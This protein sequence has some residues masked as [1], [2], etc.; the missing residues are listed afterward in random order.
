MP[1]TYLTTPIYYVNDRPHIGHAYTSLATDVL[2][3]WKRLDGHDVHFLT[4]TD[5]HGQKVEKA[6]QD[7]GMDPQ[8][9]TDRVSQHFRD[10]ADRMGFSHD[11]FIR[12]TEPRHKA[13]CQALWEE[14]VRRDEI[15]LGHYEGW[16]AVRD[17][18]FYGPDELVERDGRKYAPSGAPVEWVREPSYF[19]RLSKWQD[20]LLRRYDLPPDHPEHLAVRPESRLNEV[21]AFVKS[22]LQDLSISRTSFTWG[23]PVPGDPAHV[24]YVWLDALANYI[25]AVGYPDTA[26]PLWRFWPADVHFVGK[27]IVRFHAIYWPAFLMA[28]DLPPPKRVFAHGWWTNEGQKI[29]KSLGNVIDPIGLIEEYGLDP[30]RYFLM[31]EVPFG[32]DGD[33]Q[34]KSLVSRLNGELADVLGNL[35]NRT[36]SLIQRNCG[37][38]LPPAAPIA[39]SE[40]DADR[41]FLHDFVEGLSKEVDALLNEQKFDAALSIIFAS[42]RAANGYITVQQ[43]W[44]LKKTDLARMQVVLRHLHTALRTFAT[45]LQPFMPG[46]MAAMLDQ[47]GVPADARQLA[48]LAVPLPDGTQLPPPSPLFRKIEAEA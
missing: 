26:N 17:E 16:Y 36:L 31:R 45:V 19:F 29:S 6:A 23:I 25:T 32:Q 10:L 9:F 11:D 8:A 2:A 7:A 41:D 3:R 48:A 33:F 27:D 18:A 38:L 46:T 5:E 13:A 15:Y 30:V 47:L 22:G 34:R 1:T 43:P 40:P 35:A 24:M 44:A 14:L 4:G 12:T 37:G 39:A 21:R 20:E 28:A 42:V